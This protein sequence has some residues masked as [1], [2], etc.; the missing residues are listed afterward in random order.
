MY[1]KTFSIQSGVKY[2]FI[3]NTKPLENKYFSLI[4][5]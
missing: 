5:M 4:S 1:N 3:K 2:W